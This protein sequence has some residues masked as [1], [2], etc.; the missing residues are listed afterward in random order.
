MYVTFF[1]TKLIKITTNPVTKMEKNYNNILS[2][3]EMDILS[4]TKILSQN[5]DILSPTRDNQI[6]SQFVDVDAMGDAV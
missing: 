3:A 2:Q 4:P 1:I 5:K 6:L